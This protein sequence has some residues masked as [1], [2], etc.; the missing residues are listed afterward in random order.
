MSI[1]RPS[2][3]NLADVI[4]VIQKHS[5]LKPT[6]R[7]DLISAV[8]RIAAWLDQQPEQV[9][10]DLPPLRERLSKIEPAR[11]NISVKTAS[12]VRSNA[13]AAIEL[14][15]LWRVM[16]TAKVQLT[17]AWQANWERLAHRRQK[18]GLSRFFRY[19]SMNGLP[20]E[21]VNDAVLERFAA[22]LGSK[23]LVKRVIGLRR[24]VPRLWNECCATV[25]HWNGRAI[26]VPD[27]RPP[28][29][30]IALSIMPPSFQDELA[31][32]MCW[33]TVEDPM[34]EN[35]RSRRLR[36]RSIR[37][38]KE[39]VH[40]A[41][42]ALVK[43]GMPAEQI[44]GLAQLVDPNNFTTILRALNRAADNKASFTV[45]SVARGL[46]IMARTWLKAPSDHLSALRL[47]RSRLPPVQTG[48]TTKNR[49]F[50]RQFED[51]ALK[52]KF[53]QLPDKLWKEAERWSKRGSPKKALVAAQLSAMIDL[54]TIAPLRL[55]DL[56][57]LK[58]GHH[59]TWPAGDK[60][61]AFMEIDT[62]KTGETY[63]CD[64]PVVLSQRLRRYR[65]DILPAVL[66]RKCE[67]FVVSHSGVVK[68]YSTLEQQ[69][70]KTIRK[71]LGIHMTIHQVRHLAAKLLL[72]ERPGAHEVVRQLLGHRSLA[73]TMAFYAG[74]N[75]KRAVKL[76]SELIETMRRSRIQRG[77]TRKSRI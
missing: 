43:S 19:C 27:Q 7:R 29:K 5:K 39:D 56:L 36:P 49:T 8:N 66:G 67:H 77:L 55:S 16:R 61:Q 18:E 53:C 32:Y 25:P 41:V 9:N 69:F 57:S 22:D 34:D 58:F 54:L 2:S 23:T 21:D 17:P 52:V 31:R 4:A 26:T 51:P 24:Q 33:C 65:D 46:I 42:N 44:K 20:P 73:A 45:Q 76:H 15:G 37:R 28:L 50:L 64:L 14:S 38:Y 13:L 47:M 30:R 75:T 48:L 71:H 63:V 59:I 12:T 6:R 74:I 3:Y 11:L 1:E 62:A 72:D 60:R 70:T 10:V 40:T 35:A 68:N